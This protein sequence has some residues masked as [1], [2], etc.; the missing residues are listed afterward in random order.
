[1]NTDVFYVYLH[2]DPI[3]QNIVYV[4]KGKNG[5]AWDVTRCRNQHPEHQKWMIGLTKQGYIPEDWVKIIDKN[6]SEELAYSKEKEYLHSFG[7]PVYNRQSG[8]KQHQ[9]KLRN[10]DAIDI[11]LAANIGLSHKE[12]AK[13]YSVSR[14]TISMIASK[15]QWKAILAGVEI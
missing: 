4:G 2:I 13:I 6:L 11:Y 15:R 12:L 14:S 5:R 3:N 9:A 8:E 1:M 7:C 10:I